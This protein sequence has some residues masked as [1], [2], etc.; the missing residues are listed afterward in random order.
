[1][2]RKRTPKYRDVFASVAERDTFGTVFDGMLQHEAFKA[3]SIGAKLFYVYCRVQSKTSRGKACLYKH[4]NEYGIIYNENDFVFPASHLKDYK[5]DRSNA[6]RYFYELEKAGFIEKKERNNHIKKVN[7][8][9]FSSKWK[10]S[11]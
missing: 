2:S 6:T 3:L 5:I 1:M 9:T 10:N 4:G 8:Y 7:V 11:S